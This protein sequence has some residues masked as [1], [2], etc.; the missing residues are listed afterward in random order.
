MLTIAHN[1]SFMQ[2][3]SVELCSAAVIIYCSASN[4]W[5]KV[6]VTERSDSADNFCGELLGAVIIQYMIKAATHGMQ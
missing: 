5:A 6:A 1:G 2:D 3:E 4:Q